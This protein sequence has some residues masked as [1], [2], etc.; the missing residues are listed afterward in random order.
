MKKLPA[1]FLAAL[2]DYH[3][4]FGNFYLDSMK[5]HGV[6]DPPPVLWFTRMEAGELV[7]TGEIGWADGPSE[8]CIGSA[9]ALG[10]RVVARVLARCG[11]G[12]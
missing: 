12:N 3:E 11:S 8:L 4:E 9:R 1:D 2:A 6:E 7:T 10:E 5:V